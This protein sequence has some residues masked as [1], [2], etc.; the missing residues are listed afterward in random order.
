MKK[1]ATKPPRKA[2]YANLCLRCEHRVAYRET[3]DAQ[4]FQC[5]D[6]LN[7][8]GVC[9]MYQPVKPLAVRPIAGERR[10]LGAGWMFAGRAQAAETGPRLE[11]AAA[12]V[13]SGGVL[14]WWRPAEG[15]LAEKKAKRMKKE[16]RAGGRK[17]KA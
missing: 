15:E 17:G 8:V 14:F 7:A 10:P 2:Q 13:K 9:Y 6:L 5:G 11:L 12:R 1:P 4:R 16:S 3:G